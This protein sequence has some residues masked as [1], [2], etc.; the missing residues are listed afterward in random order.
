MH[1]ALRVFLSLY[2]LDSE[3]TS[4]NTWVKLIFFVSDEA[5]A[6][7]KDGSHPAIPLNFSVGGKFDRA[8]LIDDSSGP[9]CPLCL[10]EC[11]ALPYRREQ[12][13]LLVHL[14]LV[15]FAPTNLGEEN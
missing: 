7:M 8:E 1:Q 5:L 14:H 15:T 10:P 2:S 6:P 11:P 3:F 9:R 13:R 4:E 12:L